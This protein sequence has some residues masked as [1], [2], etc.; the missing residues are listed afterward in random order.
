MLALA[1]PESSLITQLIGVYSCLLLRPSISFSYRTPENCAHTSVIHPSGITSPPKITETSPRTYHL[2]NSGLV[3]LNPSKELS[4]S[5]KHFLFTSPEVPTF[6]F[7]DQDLLAAF[8]KGKWKVLPYCY[9]ALKTLRIIHQPLW[10]DEEI[11][12]LHYILHD[13]PWTIPPGGA[14]EYEETH[15]WWWD[16]YRKVGEEMKQTD[17]KGWQLVDSFVT[18][19]A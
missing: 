5:V 18:K 2:L 8:F 6:S 10:R 16:R 13:K 4:D 19:S 7:P 12:C 11:R 1:T 15:S 14:G 3:I 17:E 9:N